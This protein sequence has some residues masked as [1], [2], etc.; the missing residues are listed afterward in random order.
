[1]NDVGLIESVVRDLLSRGG[2]NEDIIDRLMQGLRSEWSA[3]MKDKHLHSFDLI[4]LEEDRCQVAGCQVTYEEYL[5]Q[6]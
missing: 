1:M 5:V 3:E 6:L 4:A 2:S